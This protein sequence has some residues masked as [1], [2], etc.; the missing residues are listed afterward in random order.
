MPAGWR[1]NSIDFTLIA[2]IDGHPESSGTVA[3]TSC[4]PLRLRQLFFTSGLAPGVQ[5]L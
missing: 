1:D 3:F 5:G 4:P 2:T